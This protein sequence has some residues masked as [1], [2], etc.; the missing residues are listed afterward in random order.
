MD[1]SVVRLLDDLGEQ[2]LREPY[3]IAG[4]GGWINAG[5]ASTSAAEHLVEHLRAHKVAELDPEWFYAFSDA[6]PTTALNVEGERIHIWPRAEIFAARLPES[7]SRDLVIFVGPEPNL[8]W[9]TFVDA[10]VDIFQRLDA[11]A[12]VSLGAILA[13]VHYRAPVQ[14]RGWGSNPEFRA[15]LRKRRISFSRYQGPTGIATVLH[16]LAQERGLPGA[17]LTAS[18]PSYVP[19]L[20][21][22]WTA[23]A[24]LRIAGDLAGLRLP[25]EPLDRAARALMTQIDE[26]LAERP[27]LRERIDAL[28]HDQGETESET[29]QAPEP[30]GELPSGEALVRD[31]E[32]FLRGLR[33]DEG[34]ST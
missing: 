29:R 11:R 14:M 18:T 31:L 17:G 1:S 9:R 16:A 6:R 8:R 15:A 19:G 12:I 30:G 21:H 7:A 25:I 28:E 4:F 5:Q 26:F 22:P 2:R 10:L 24:L 32:D 33:G 3:V 23:A 34:G 20:V 27:T 13:P